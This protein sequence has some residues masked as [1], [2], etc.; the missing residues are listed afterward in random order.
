MKTQNQA[1]PQLK[2]SPKSTKDRLYD[3]AKIEYPDGP[4]GCA[5]CIASVQYKRDQ[6]VHS[7]TR[8]MQDLT[9]KEIQSLLFAL[10]NP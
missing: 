2:E 7:W 1:T 3:L 4:A 5:G 10:E 8:D 9:E 6:F